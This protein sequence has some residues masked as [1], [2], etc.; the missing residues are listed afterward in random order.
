MIKSKQL[1]FNLRMIVIDNLSC[2]FSNIPQR[3]QY[4]YNLIKELLYYMKT[5]TKKYFISV[6]YTNNTKDANVTRVT[7]LKNLVGEPLTWAVDKQIYAH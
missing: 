4:Y 6:V 2:L 5:L 1:T 7:E 3:G